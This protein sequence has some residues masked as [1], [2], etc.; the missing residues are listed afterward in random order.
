MDVTCGLRSPLVGFA[1]SAG[2]ILQGMCNDP[3]GS[4]IRSEA[5]RQALGKNNR[6]CAFVQVGA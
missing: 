3:P 6:W 2:R 5:V 4:P 1:I